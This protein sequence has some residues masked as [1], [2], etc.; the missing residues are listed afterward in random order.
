MTTFIHTATILIVEDDQF[1]RQSMALFL[2]KCGFHV[3]QA[4]NGRDGLEIFIQKVPDLIILDLQMPEMSGLELLAAIRNDLAVIPAIV[5]SGTGTMNVVIETL[6]FGAWDYLTKPFERLAILELAVNKALEKARLIKENRHYQLHLEE[7]VIQRTAE[8]QLREQEAQQIFASVHFAICF[9]DTEMRVIRLN[10]AMEA[11]VGFKS[12]EARGHYCYDCWGQYAGDKIRQGRE[13]ICDTCQVASTLRSG[14][15]YSY[16]RKIGDKIVEITTNPVWDINGKIIGA[17]EVADDITERKNNEVILE[18]HRQQ[19]QRL[20]SRLMETEEIERRRIASKLHDQ[21]GQ[22]L[23]ALGLNL[24]IMGQ[25]V[26]PEQRK[27]IDDSLEL[28]AAMTGQVRDIMADLRPPVLDDYGLGPALRW[29][30]SV[31]CKRTGVEVIVYA[32]IPRLPANLEIALFRIIQEALNNVIKHAHA[33]KV[34]VHCSMNDNQL[35]LA[36]ED[37][38]CGFQGMGEDVLPESQT[39]GLLS[40]RER[41][42]T[43]GGKLIVVSNP[44]SGTVVTVKVQI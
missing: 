27:R 1:V 8:L 2:E 21:I 43:F 14:E 37:N 19:L 34:E 12:E 10:P 30:G 20:S 42:E 6:R 32:G 9:V 18:Q 5:V 28:I 41:I 23:T 15:K 24:H 26:P 40:M 25:S 39:W 11:L 3:L 31:F 44:G 16:E 13:K 7:E 38:G 22:E 4:A 17:M 33:T 29:Y 35:S 36:I